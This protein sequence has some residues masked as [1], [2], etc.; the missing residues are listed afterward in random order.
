MLLLNIND[1]SN[2]SEETVSD[3]S[4]GMITSAL[5][6]RIRIQSDLDKLENGL[7]SKRQNSIDTSAHTNERKTNIQIPE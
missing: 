6:D 2:T 4:V 3:I 7:K 5:V 1:L